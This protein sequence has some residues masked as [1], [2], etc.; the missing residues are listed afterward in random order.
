[1]ESK[2]RIIEAK[3]AYPVYIYNSFKEL[4]VIFPSVSTLAKLIKSNH[5]TIV[6]VIKEKTIFRGEWYLVNTPYNISDTPVIT[7]WISKECDE[8]ILNMNN[9]SHVKKAVFVYDINKN[10]ICKYDG[11]MEAQKALNINHSTIKK[12][13]K[14]GGIYKDYVFS[15]ERLKD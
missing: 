1:M 11:V 4:I 15:Y 5:S 7:N 6:D 2:V 13:A 12:Y 3:S 14:V 8:L 9:H 10:F